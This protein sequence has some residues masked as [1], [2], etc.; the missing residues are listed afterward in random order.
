MHDRKKNRFL[1]PKPR[2]SSHYSWLRALL[3]HRAVVRWPSFKVVRSW[4]F[5]EKSP[6]LLP[7]LLLLVS[8]TNDCRLTLRMSRLSFS[9]CSF[10]ELIS[11]STFRSSEDSRRNSWVTSWV[12]ADDCF[13]D[14]CCC[15]KYR[16]WKLWKI[17]QKSVLAG[18]SF[19][20]SL[21]NRSK[22]PLHK[23]SRE[24]RRKVL[25]KK[26]KLFTE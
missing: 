13:F 1:T 11:D 6:T 5:G 2:S 7:F 12:T 20:S 21:D 14:S 19:D 25:C 17:T 3:D 4:K 24:F 26:V 10:F 9:I 18:I 16:R 8:R 23:V 15:S 22:L